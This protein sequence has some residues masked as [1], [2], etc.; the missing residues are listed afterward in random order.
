MSSSSDSNNR[1]YATILGGLFAGG[2][3]KLITH[4]IDTMKAK[5]QVQKN[6][7]VGEELKMYGVRY[8]IK[9]TIAEEGIRGFYPGVGIAV[10]GGIP[11]TSLYFSTYEIS[12]KYLKNHFV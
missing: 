4:P 2:I 1:T 10:L 11:G 5:L 8:M 9:K 7:L 12:K 6:R 3:N